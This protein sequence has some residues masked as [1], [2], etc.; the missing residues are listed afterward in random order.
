MSVLIGGGKRSIVSMI[1]PSWIK[2]WIERSHV[3][4]VNLLYSCSAVC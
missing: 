3:A 1:P 4:V 2:L